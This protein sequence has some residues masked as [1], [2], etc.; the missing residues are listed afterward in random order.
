MKIAANLGV[1]DEEDLIG[2]C[3]EHLR[4]IGVDLIVVTDIGSTDGTRDVLR[5]LAG[6]DLRLTELGPDDDPWGFPQRMYERTVA[7][8]AV[9]RVLSLDAD[10]FWLPRTGSIRD[11]TGLFGA[12]VLTVPRFNV[13]PVVG[14]PLL[15]A[16]LSPTTLGDVSLVVKPIEQPWV[17]IPENPRL[18][19]VMSRVLPK[20]V[21]NPRA[22]QA[23]AVGGHASVP[24]PGVTA[25]T[26]ACED[27]LIAHAP[28]STYPRFLRKLQNIG[29]SLERFGPRLPQ[30]QAWHWRRWVELERTGQA[31][32]E[33]H[34]QFLTEEQFQG[35]LADGTIVS[36]REWLARSP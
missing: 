24:R 14:R 15:P 33:F 34:R 11:A 35:A 28:F 5:G 30:D 23:F 4:A 19:W 31:E 21:V 26:V 17:K 20:V 8:F 36:A 32:V 29:R 6:P 1:L 3:I 27:V 16:V 10:E 18:A 22:I 7:E 12:D 2:P 13:P 25:T 9:D